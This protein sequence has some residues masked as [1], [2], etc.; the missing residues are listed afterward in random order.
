MHQPSYNYHNITIPPKQISR[1]GLCN[2][3]TVLFYVGQ[4]GLLNTGWIYFMLQTIK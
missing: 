3:K 4:T 2:G 1:I